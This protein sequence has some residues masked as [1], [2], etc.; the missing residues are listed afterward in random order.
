MRI[1]NQ[2]IFDENA[3][4]NKI[5]PVFKEIIAD[6]LTP[7]ATF[8]KLQKDRK[9]IYLLESI[10]GNSNIG[11]YS[12]IGLDSHIIFKAKKNEITIINVNDPEQNV[13]KKY[14]LN[15]IV[16]LENLVKEIDSGLRI[17]L[18]LP[19]F[20][21]GA[22]GYIG[23][24][25][26]CYFEKSLK[27]VIELKNKDESFDFEDMYFVFPKDIII[28][29]RVKNTITIASNILVSDNKNKDYDLGIQRIK[30]IENEVF[31]NNNKNIELLE[32]VKNQKKELK[33]DIKQSHS[34]NAYEEMVLK[35]KDYIKKGDIFQ[36]VLSQRWEIDYKNGN[37]QNE[38]SDFD[39]YRYLRVMNPSPYMFFLKFD[40][41]SIIGA[42]PES[43]AKRMNDKVILRPIAGTRKR[44]VN[45]EIDKALEIELLNDEKEKAEHIMLLD[46][47]R[48]DIGRIAKK[49]TVKVDE[50]MTI[51]RYSHVMHIVSQVGCEVEK[52]TKFADIMKAVF[53]AGTVSGAPK[54]RA[55]EII[56]ELENIN[57]GIYA[58]S[59][60]YLGFNQNFDSCI[61]LRTILKKGNKIFIQ[62]GAGIVADS[63]PETEYFETVNKAKVLFEAVAKTLNIDEFKLK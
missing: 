53:P 7:V 15:P 34:K 18:D 47:G 5:F 36:I 28:F 29:D 10:E 59:I 56:N 54:I 27:K 4:K 52:E 3:R 51:E 31:L 20:Y 38:I 26:V 25:S 43:L 62:A 32:C 58:G 37:E 41:F 40:D 9:H 1:L 23:Y 30:D 8:L 42:S 12:F 2:R 61:T 33:I 46:L 57:R 16:E 39:I 6:T 45:Y 50:Y 11:R 48:N 19:P 49:G 13:D 22:V 24:N 14:S 60:V 21:G 63:D 44:S 17:N 55:I 35:A